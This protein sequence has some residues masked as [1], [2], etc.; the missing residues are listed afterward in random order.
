[1]SGIGI[2]ENRYESI[3]IITIDSDQGIKVVN[4]EGGWFKNSNTSFSYEKGEATRILPIEFLRNIPLSSMPVNDLEQLQQI[5]KNYSSILAKYEN[6]IEFNIALRIEVGIKLYQN[7]IGSYIKSPKKLSAVNFIVKS[8]ET[9]KKFQKGFGGTDRID[10]IMNLEMELESLI[11]STIE[12]KHA[13]SPMT[14][15]Y[16]VIMDS[17]ATGLFA[18]EVIG[19][20]FEADIWLNSLKLQQNLALGKRIGSEKFNVI[21]NPLLKGMYGSYMHDDE[22]ILAQET[23]IIKNG[24]VNSLLHSKH[25]ASLMGGDSTGNGRALSYKYEPIVRMSNTYIAPGEKEANELLEETDYG[26]YLKGSNNSLGGETFN[27]GC[28]EAFLIEKGKITKRLCDLD[29]YGE[30]YQTLD[31]IVD[32]ANDFRMYGGGDGGC[33]KA[34]QWPLPVGAG[35][36]HIKVNNLFVRD[37]KPGA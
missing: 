13:I 33:G 36:P 14:G 20:N 21:D 18:H 17:E 29:I 34:G 22:G 23:Y 6:H 1:M 9:K 8:L 4:R 37:K 12:S 15:F 11:Q 10:S 31:N 16:T 32:I 26:I 19:H 5:V 35:G 7:S 28:Q 3:H 27:L 30:M 24:V 25:T 2:M